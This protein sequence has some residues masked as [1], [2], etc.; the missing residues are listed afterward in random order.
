MTYNVITRF[1][2]IYENMIGIDNIPTIIEL[3]L[4]RRTL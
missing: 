3:I 2:I 1:V 4:I